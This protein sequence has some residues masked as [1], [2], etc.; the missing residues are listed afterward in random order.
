MAFVDTKKEEEKK[1]PV[2]RVRVAAQLKIRI[3]HSSTLKAGVMVML[4]R[5]RN[6]V[7]ERKLVSKLKMKFCRM[8]EQ[9]GI[10]SI[11]QTNMLQHRADPNPGKSTWQ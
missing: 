6:F 7:R 8:I 10:F 2:Y 5:H 1:G 4:H 3:L 11:I 9:E